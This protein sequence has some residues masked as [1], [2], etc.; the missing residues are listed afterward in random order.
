MAK[1][2]ITDVPILNFQ[3]KTAAPIILVNIANS[4]VEALMLLTALAHALFFSRRSNLSSFVM[5]IHVCI[6]FLIFVST[7]VR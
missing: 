4:A 6:L 3:L 1:V 7:S 5:L 2:N